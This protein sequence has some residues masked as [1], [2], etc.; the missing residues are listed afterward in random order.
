M[1]QETAIPKSSSTEK[2]LSR[3][4]WFCLFVF[5]A[6]AIDLVTKWWVFHS[7]KFGEKV[8]IVSGVLDFIPTYNEGAVFGMGKGGRWIFI[9][10]S[11]L[12]MVFIWQ[13]YKTSRSEQKGFQFLLAMTFGGAIGNLY[14]RFVHEKVRDFIELPIQ[15]AGIHLWPYIFNIADVVLVVGVV[16]LLVGW[17]FGIFELRTTCPIARPLVS[18]KQTINSSD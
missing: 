4:F 3:H 6:A 15:L 13:L 2:P 17:I 5:L 14:D 9:G 16:G 10:A 8:I 7:L 18:D 1:N 12:A 11:I